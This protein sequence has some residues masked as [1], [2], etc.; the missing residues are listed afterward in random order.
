MYVTLPGKKSASS[1]FHSAAH[2]L[3]EVV[4][5]RL[6]G[7][8][9]LQ[10]A[11]GEGFAASAQDVWNQ[12]T[13]QSKQAENRSLVRCHMQSESVRNGWQTF[14]KSEAQRYRGEK[15]SPLGGIFRGDFWR[16]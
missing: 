15:K 7:A 9:A 13:A 16:Q 4:N 1:E 6:R 10:C 12:L 8:S 14:I 2:E 11:S 5:P 3:Y